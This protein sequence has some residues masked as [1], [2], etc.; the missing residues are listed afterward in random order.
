M[1]IAMASAVAIRTGLPVTD[2]PAVSK[3]HQTKGRAES[4]P[5]CVDQG[6][7]LS[8]QRVM[9]RLK[10]FGIASIMQILS[11]VCLEDTVSAANPCFANNRLSPTGSARSEEL[12]L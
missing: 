11:L 3:T 8:S 5:A 10:V 1:R 6:R 2:L 9:R 12:S 4:P 7:P